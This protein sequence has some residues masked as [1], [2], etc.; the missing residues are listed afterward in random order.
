[1]ALKSP[2]SASVPWASQASYLP[3]FD[4]KQDASKHPPQPSTAP[5][6]PSPSR[7]AVLERAYDLGCTN[8]DTAD[9]SLD[10]EDLIGKWFARTG[11]RNEIFLV[12]RFANINKPDGTRMRRSDPEYVREA[13]E[14]SLRRFGG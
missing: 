5:P 14:K 9:I 7:L 11:K 3:K 13:C 4:H 1:M 6:S 10:N 8:W 12:T 2:P